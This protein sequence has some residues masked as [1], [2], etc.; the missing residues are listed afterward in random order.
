MRHRPETK[1]TSP[2]PK[3]HRS[4]RL[5]PGLRAASSAAAAEPATRVWVSIITV[6]VSD[7]GAS[8][9]RL[10]GGHKPE[11]RRGWQLNFAA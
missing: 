10:V 1:P 7:R 5:A 11:G 2:V 8:P 6:T 4:G 3:A 9:P